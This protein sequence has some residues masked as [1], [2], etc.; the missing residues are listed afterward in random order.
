[1]TRKAAGDLTNQIVSLA[2]LAVGRD[3]PRLLVLRNLTPHMPCKWG[4]HAESW[5]A[6]PATEATDRSLVRCQSHGVRVH[7]HGA[8]QHGAR[9][10]NQ[11]SGAGRD[12]RGDDTVLA[13]LLA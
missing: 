12:K 2:A 8:L 7:S 13:H 9:C 3:P 11:E 10:S 1:M 4:A 6:P 5:H